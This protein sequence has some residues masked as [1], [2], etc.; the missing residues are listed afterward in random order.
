MSI[1]LLITK[2]NMLQNTIM[3]LTKPQ[4]R[5]SKINIFFISKFILFLVQSP[6][7]RIRPSSSNVGLQSAV[8]IHG[9]GSFNQ[10]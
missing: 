5:D 6:V 10:W 7:I 9:L 4:A 1:I 3:N 8:N 2:Q